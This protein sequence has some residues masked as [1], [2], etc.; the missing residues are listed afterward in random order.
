M[1]FINEQWFSIVW[2]VGIFVVMYFVMIRPQSKQRKERTTMI[3]SLKKGDRVITV[4]GMYGII[5]AIRDDRITLEVASGIYVQFTKTAIGTLT[6]KEERESKT[7]EPEAIASG[8][9]DEA[10]V[11]A[12]TVD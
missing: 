5:R 6:R 11:E 12:S 4:G 7:P 3:N 1:S 2:I 8:S 10:E 9:G